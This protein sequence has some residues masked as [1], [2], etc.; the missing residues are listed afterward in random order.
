[1]TGFGDAGAVDPATNHILMRSGDLGAS[2]V[3]AAAGHET[4]ADMLLAEMAAMG[5]NTS[6]TAMVAWQGP[7]GLMME[8]SAAEFIA[9]C[10]AASAWARISRAQ[11]S[12]VAAGHSAALASMIPAEVVFANRTTQGGLI[13]TNVFGIHTG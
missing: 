9:I 11:A 10:E 3:A 8:M 7:G 1:M 4:I 5:L 12:E 6:S 2:L 13:A